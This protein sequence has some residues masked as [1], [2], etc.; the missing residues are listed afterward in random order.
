MVMTEKMAINQKAMG[1]E[2]RFPVAPPSVPAAVVAWLC[3]DPEAADH[4]GE[5]FAAQKFAK[6]RGLHPTWW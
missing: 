6:E 1:L 2:N 4:N 5:T 3:S